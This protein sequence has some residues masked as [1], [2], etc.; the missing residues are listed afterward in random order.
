MSVIPV[1]V[2]LVLALAGLVTRKKYRKHKQRAIGKNRAGESSGQAKDKN[3]LRRSPA[4][5]R[6]KKMKKKDK[7]RKICSPG[8]KRS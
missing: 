4:I 2:D 8:W 5:L 1:W 3:D 6:R 7:S